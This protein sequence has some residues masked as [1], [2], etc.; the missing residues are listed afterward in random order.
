MRR[1]WLLAISIATAVAFLGRPAAARPFDFARAVALVGQLPGFDEPAVTDPRERVAG[2]VELLAQ[3]IADPSETA[4]SI[5]HG[6]APDPLT[7]ARQRANLVW[8]LGTPI[9]YRGTRGLCPPELVLQAC[10]NARDPELRRHLAIAV[11]KAGVPGFT[12]AAV[13]TAL[14][15]PDH[16]MREVAVRA[17]VEQRDPRFIPLFVHAL[18]DPVWTVASLGR[19]GLLKLG[20]QV[21]QDSSGYHVADARGKALYTVNPKTRA[22]TPGVA[23]AAAGAKPGTLVLKSAAAPNQPAAAPAKPAPAPKA[24]PARSPKR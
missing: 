22:V 4:Q 18:G 24:T 23:A 10:L 9:G 8:Y 7:S 13:H 19:S 16:P 11:T 21:R 15:D 14:N 6:R 5:Q 17:L 12:D 2:L 1:I 3:E 20:F